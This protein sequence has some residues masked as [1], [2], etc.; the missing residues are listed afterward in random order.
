MYFKLLL[1]ESENGIVNRCFMFICRN[2]TAVKWA[3]ARGDNS[4]AASS[5][6]QI[7]QQE[8]QIWVRSVSYLHDSFTYNKKSNWWLREMLSERWFQILNAAELK[9]HQ[10][11]IKLHRWKL[12]IIW[13]ISQW[14]TKWSTL[15]QKQHKIAFTT[16]TAGISAVWKW[17]QLNCLQRVHEWHARV[18]IPQGLD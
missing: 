4:N 5:P 11:G 16:H 17:Q 3:L 12:V 13:F 8:G 2:Q 1:P 14:W 10:R 6:A 7:L 9:S 15:L 18:T